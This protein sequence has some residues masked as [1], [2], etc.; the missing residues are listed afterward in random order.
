MTLED[1]TLI[2]KE[3]ALKIV[4]VLAAKE[5]RVRDV[6]E[7]LRCVKAEID[8]QIIRSPYGVY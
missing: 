6:D 3:I 8:E 1:T 2:E 7:I 4:D 5:V